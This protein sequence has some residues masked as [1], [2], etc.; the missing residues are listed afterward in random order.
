MMLDR[1]TKSINSSAFVRV[2]LRLVI[3]E[4]LFYEHSFLG[5]MQ[6]AYC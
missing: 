5:L 1:I 2:Y 4:I 3:I 6:L